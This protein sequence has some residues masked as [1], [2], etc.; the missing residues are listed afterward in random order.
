MLFIH[1]LWRTG[2]TYLWNKYRAQVG[3]IAYFEPFHEALLDAREATLS[4]QFVETNLRLRHPDLK[5]HYFAEFPFQPEGGVAHFRKELSYDRYILDEEEAAPETAAYLTHLL[6][7]A[8]SCG[9]IPIFQCNR[10]AFRTAWMRRRF[11]GRHL[12]ILRDPIDQFASYLDL[13][14][15][16]YFLAGTM[17][18][19]GKAQQHPLFQPLA[20]V[21]T[22]PRID[23]PSVAEEMDLYHRI[24]L[25]MPV[26]DVLTVHFYLWLVGFL[27]NL[28]HADFVIDMNLTGESADHRKTVEA[29]L[30][31]VG[32]PVSLRDC[33][34]PRS[35]ERLHVD[36][37][38][39]SWR[40][41]WGEEDGWM[42]PRR[43]AVV[44]ARVLQIVTDRLRPALRLSEQDFDDRTSGVADHLRLLALPF[45][46]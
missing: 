33:Q 28:K 25:Q 44:Q 21:V 16:P 38:P 27:Y 20:E 37:L 12:Y 10:T 6:T 35:G 22:L 31:G 14:G 32:F 42:E 45:V 43:F 2:S 40:N 39:E 8:R 29:K 3:R 19:A 7:H 1:A 13:A 9:K 46:A 41:S 18:V 15:N 34:L 26:L 23:R 5:A 17:L 24:A 36:L 30:G 4:D 11:G